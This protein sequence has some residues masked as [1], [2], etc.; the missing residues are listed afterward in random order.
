[1]GSCRASVTLGTWGAVVPGV[2]VNTWGAVAAGVHATYMHMV[3]ESVLQQR[4]LGQC[5]HMCQCITD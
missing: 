2:P 1:M 3:R 5:C 4:L